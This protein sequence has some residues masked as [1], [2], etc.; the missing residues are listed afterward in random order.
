[1]ASLSFPLFLS[2][3]LTRATSPDA[4]ARIG[5]VSAGL[6]EPGVVTVPAPSVNGPATEGAVSDSAVPPPNVTNT[7]VRTGGSVGVVIGC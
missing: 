1:M 3:V 7:P 2:A 4:F 6:G 5:T